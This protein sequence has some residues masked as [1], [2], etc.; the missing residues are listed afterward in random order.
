MA[1]VVVTTTL[2][3]GLVSGHRKSHP[4]LHADLRI[5]S[6]R[7]A[8]APKAIGDQIPGLSALPFSVFKGRSKD[9][10][11][12]LGASGGWRIIYDVD[13]ENER[14]RLL[15]LYHKRE[16]E[17]PPVEFLLEKLKAALKS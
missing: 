9:S 12:K 2:F 7:A 5:S 10:C 11:H 4:K 13:D 17:N 8:L 15:F 6:E 14:V 3:D 1:S 16:V